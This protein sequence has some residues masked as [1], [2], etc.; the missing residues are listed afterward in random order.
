M[1]M[2]VFLQLFFTLGFEAGSLNEPEYLWFSHSC[3]PLR[4]RDSSVSASQLR[5]QVCTTTP[6]PAFLCWCWQSKFKSSC[7]HSWHFTHWAISAKISVRISNNSSIMSVIPYN[8]LNRSTVR[9]SLRMAK[10]CSLFCLLTFFL[11]K[12]V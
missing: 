7:L 4:T 5:F 11:L 12:W 1:C 8:C 3:W 9:H 10:F 2:C 6:K